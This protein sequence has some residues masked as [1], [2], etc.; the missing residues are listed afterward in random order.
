[1]V[2]HDSRDQFYIELSQK[3]EEKQIT[4]QET[5]DFVNNTKDHNASDLYELCSKFADIGLN[6]PKKAD[7][8][9]C[10]VQSCFQ[11]SDINAA[12]SAFSAFVSDNDICD[13]EGLL[14]TVQLMHPFAVAWDDPR[15]KGGM[16]RPEGYDWKPGFAGKYHNFCQLPDEIWEQIKDE[17][18]KEM[19][20]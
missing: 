4:S 14:E 17:I 20:Q 11:F 8:K 5:I 9:T 3:I 18:L 15:P 6:A 12:K 10:D 7:P 19:M 2:L 13:I 1:M 16:V